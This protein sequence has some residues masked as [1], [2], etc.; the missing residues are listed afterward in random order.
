MVELATFVDRFK[1]LEAFLKKESSNLLLKHNN[2]IVPLANSQLLKGVNVEGQTM[3]RGYSTP[4]GKRRGKK[5]LQT[6]FVDLKFSGKYQDTKKLVAYDYGVDIRSA[7]DYE[8]YLRANFPG[9]VGLTEPN[10]EVIG[11]KMADDIS[12]LIE[13]YLT[14]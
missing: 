7:A 3:Q 2:D 1:G 6:G 11:A 4:Y 8:A 12:V 5:G 14:K 13:N 9:H 10:A